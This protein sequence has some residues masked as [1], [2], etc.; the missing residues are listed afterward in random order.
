MRGVGPIPLAG[1]CAVPRD[2]RRAGSG[3]RLSAEDR[4]KFGRSRNLLAI[5]ET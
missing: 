5:S 2:I 1:E 4:V 3:A